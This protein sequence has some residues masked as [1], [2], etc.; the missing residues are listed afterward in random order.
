MVSGFSADIIA[1]SSIWIKA[2]DGIS[3]QRKYRHVGRHEGDKSRYD[4]LSLIID[5]TQL[6]CHIQYDIDKFSYSHHRVHK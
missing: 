6:L 5:M 2:N 4:E 3:S 1:V